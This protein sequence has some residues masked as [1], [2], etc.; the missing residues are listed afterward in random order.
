V[1]Y[2]PAIQLVQLFGLVAAA[3]IPYDPA[4]QGVHAEEE[5]APTRALY[6]PGTHGKHEDG[7]SAY[8]PAGQFVDDSEHAV[9]PDALYDSTAHG[10]HGATPSIPNVPGKHP[11]VS[12]KEPLPTNVIIPP[13]K[14]GADGLPV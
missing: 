7:A 12:V 11:R 13:T 5:V 14:R 10:V 9:A 2:I 6:V 1:L 4:E 3:R 8:V